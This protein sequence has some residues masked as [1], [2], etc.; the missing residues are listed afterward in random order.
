M[1]ATRNRHL[2]V[3]CLWYQCPIYL[4]TCP[5]HTQSCCPAC[6]PPT[7]A[8]SLPTS[9]PTTS[10]SSHPPHSTQAACQA[11]ITPIPV[12]PPY[13][14]RVRLMMVTSPSC[15]HQC[16]L[17]QCSNSYHHNVY[18]HTPLISSQSPTPDNG[19]N[20][21]GDNPWGNITGSPVGGSH[22]F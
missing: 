15:F 9:F 7:P 12:P 14:T 21:Y 8:M 17:H 20:M 18:S 2:Q 1:C 16:H 19:D 3:D 4:C 13:T 11:N 22:F 5:G 10:C 6:C